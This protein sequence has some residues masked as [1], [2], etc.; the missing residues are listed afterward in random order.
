MGADRRGQISI[1]HASGGGLN[2][3]V[4]ANL[5]RGQISNFHDRGS[6]GL[7]LTARFSTG[8]VATGRGAGAAPRSAGSRLLAARLAGPRDGASSAGSARSSRRITSWSRLRAR[9]FWGFS[10]RADSSAP[11][12]ASSCPASRQHR[13]S[14]VHAPSFS[15]ASRVSSSLTARA[16]APKSPRLAKSTAFCCRDEM[17]ATS[18]SMP[19]GSDLEFPRSRPPGGDSRSDPVAG[20]RLGQISTP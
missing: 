8:R 3:T 7:E 16:S 14:R 1:F 2:F 19:R 5:A 18:D 15:G 13:A 9:L 20:R 17:S 10:S 12:A 11:L 6:V 4:L